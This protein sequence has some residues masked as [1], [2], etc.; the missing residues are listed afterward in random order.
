MSKSRE[1][2]LKKGG[3]PDGPA[4]EESKGGVKPGPT[5]IIKAKDSNDKPGKPSAA[6][7]AALGI[8]PQ[9]EDNK[10]KKPNGDNGKAGNSGSKAAR[11]GKP[12]P[13]GGNKQLKRGGTG[14]D[15]KIIKPKVKRSSLD[16]LMIAF[17]FGDGKN[18]VL[19]DPRYY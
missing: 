18:A 3:K 5:T 11:G 2:K 7:A 15:N 14:G 8:R 13:K 6:T 12:G 16:K 9:Q 17:G 19:R 10:K 1:E 4:P